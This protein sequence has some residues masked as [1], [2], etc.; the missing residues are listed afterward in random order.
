MSGFGALRGGR[1]GEGTLSEE[2]LRGSGRTEGGREGKGRVRLCLP[3][4]TRPK[5][6]GRGVSRLLRLAFPR[7]VCFCSSGNRGLSP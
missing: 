7:E 2:G 1:V 6:G 4:E 3:P 5:H